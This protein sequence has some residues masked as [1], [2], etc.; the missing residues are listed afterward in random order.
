MKKYLP[1]V[2]PALA[3]LVVLFLGYRW[4]VARS[5][6]MTPAAVAEGAKIEELSTTQLDRLQ[7]MP[8]ADLKTVKLEGS[9]AG[10]GEVR[11]EL[12]DGKVLM[13]LTADLQT[14]KAGESY[15][16][17]LAR[18]KADGT[19]ESR[20]KAFELSDSKSGYMGS[21]SFS[22]ELLPFTVI[23]T[24]TTSRT[25]MGEDILRGVVQK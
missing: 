14:L 21:A 19:E 16:V 22:Q 1:F 15:T 9:E 18:L 13:S 6:S 12:Q 20:Q 10:A 11:Y 8:A 23:V 2:F 24:R 17:W 3:L 4:Y 25:P 5:S 7:K